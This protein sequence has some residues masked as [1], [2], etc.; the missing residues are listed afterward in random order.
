MK[1][2]KYKNG[3]NF[4][5]L[6]ICHAGFRGCQAILP[7]SGVSKSQQHS[8]M[9]VSQSTSA[10][11]APLSFA[12]YQYVNTVPTK[13]SN[14]FINL[15]GIRTPKSLEDRKIW[16]LICW[17]KVC[18]WWL[19]FAYSCPLSLPMLHY[20]S[21]QFSPYPISPYSSY[22]VDIKNGIRQLNILKI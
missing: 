5:S 10:R 3:V 21:V 15:P 19:G 7:N 18:R 12:E 20:T 22:A 2:V 1:W 17:S 14:I 11:K 16:D 9:K 4:T 6:N 8:E 13:T